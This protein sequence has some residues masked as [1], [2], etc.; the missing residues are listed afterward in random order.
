M[1]KN[2]GAVPAARLE[3]GGTIEGVE[4]DDRGKEKEER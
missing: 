4:T 2:P 1:R 3:A